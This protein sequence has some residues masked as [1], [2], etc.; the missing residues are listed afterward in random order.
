MDKTAHHRY[1]T[2]GQDDRSCRYCH[3]ECYIDEDDENA[4]WQDGATA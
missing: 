2:G 4:F 3:G 1:T